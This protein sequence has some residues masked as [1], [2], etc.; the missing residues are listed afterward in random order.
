[1]P[2]SNGLDECGIDNN[3]DSDLRVV[4]RKLTKKDSTTKIRVN[5]KENKIIRKLISLYFQRPLMNYGIIVMLMNLMKKFER[6]FHFSFHIIE[7]GR[8]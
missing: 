5:L 6:F 4:L 8:P 7:N 1:M 3:I 2:I